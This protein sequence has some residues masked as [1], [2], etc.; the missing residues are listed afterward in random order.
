MFLSAVRRFLL[1]VRPS[2][3]KG[4]PGRE[5]WECLWG[6]WRQWRWYIWLIILHLSALEALFAT[7]RY[8]NWHLHCVAGLS[9]WN[10]LPDSLQNPIRICH[11]SLITILERRCEPF[12]EGP[13]E[14]D[15]ISKKIQEV[16]VWRKIMQVRL[17]NAPAK[18]ATR[19]LDW[20]YKILTGKE[21][22]DR[23]DFFKLQARNFHNTR[24]HSYKLETSR[25]RLEL[26]QNFFSQRVTTHKSLE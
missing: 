21:K 5:G 14:S 2:R 15:Q 25:I 3:Y 22:V 9:V 1:S 13:E 20:T 6:I 11:T 12:G 24:G 18:K 7:M 16:T 17:D 26:H 8:I 10:S 4:R 23:N 19:R